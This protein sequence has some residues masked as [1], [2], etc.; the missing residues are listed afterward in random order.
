[1]QQFKA[2]MNLLCLYPSQL[3]FARHIAEESNL[4]H[5]FHQ[6]AYKVWPG[7][8]SC[9]HE[10]DRL[11]GTQGSEKVPLILE[12]LRLLVTAQSAKTVDWQ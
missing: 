11:S 12:N 6:S 3:R 5:Q 1:M 7:S 9:P 10:N 8:G 2:D 4:K